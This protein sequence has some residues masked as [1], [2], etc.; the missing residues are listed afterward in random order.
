M[1]ILRRS[2]ANG[3]G[4]KHGLP[5]AVLV[6]S[7]SLINCGGDTDDDKGAAGGS[8]GASSG[9]SAGSA[10]GG[11]G[12]TTTG[13]NGGATSGGSGGVA[14]GGNSGTAGSA[15]SG[16]VGSVN[17]GGIS[18]PPTEC[19][20]QEYCCSGK[21]VPDSAP[22]SGYA[23]QCDDDADCPGQFCCVT[24]LG[25]LDGGPQV[26]QCQASCDADTQLI[27]C[28][29][30]LSPGGCPPGMSCEITAT[31]PPSYGYCCPTGQPCSAT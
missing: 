2:F 14:T 31:L 12:G 26:A 18:S 6:V 29:A 30:P 24:K 25:K 5:A 4:S 21:C 10:T 8:G 16:A 23:F 9:G 15:G 20:P 11:F 1:S 19:G 13:G 27:V 28:K 22:C 7:C 3:S 17:C